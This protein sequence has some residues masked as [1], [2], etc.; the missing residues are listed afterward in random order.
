MGESNSTP[1]LI[2]GLL[3]DIPLPEPEPQ[4]DTA[5]TR[6]AF[7]EIWELVTGAAAEGVTYG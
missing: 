2:P 1:Q 6:E 3:F 7:A 4:V 5:A